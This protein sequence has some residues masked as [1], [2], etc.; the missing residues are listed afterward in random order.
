[1][2]VEIIGYTTC[3]A[4]RCSI[5]LVVFECGA[6]CGQGLRT[7]RS[8][9]M[10]FLLSAPSLQEIAMFRYDYETTLNRFENFDWCIVCCKS[11]FISLVSCFRKI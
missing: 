5:N 2:L 11:S 3:G 6:A 10:H 7:Q 9:R 4:A 8:M 1:M